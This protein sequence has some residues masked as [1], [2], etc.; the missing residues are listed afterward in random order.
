MCKESNRHYSISSVLP[1]SWC[2]FKTL[3]ETP[4][5]TY[6]EESTFIQG[7]QGFTIKKTVH[8]ILQI[9]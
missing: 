8:G 1:W 4:K 7:F 6:F 3:G 9:I 2:L 5:F